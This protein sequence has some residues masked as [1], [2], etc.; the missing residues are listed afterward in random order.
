VD[1]AGRRSFRAGLRL[2]VPFAVASFLLST[3]FGVIARETGFSLVAAVV[4]SL[5]VFAGSAQ[6]AAV[7]VL[8]SGGGPGA[9]VAAGT[10]M[11]ARFLPMGVALAPSLPGRAWWRGLQGQAV[12]DSSWAVASRGD[13]TFDRWLLFGTTAPQLVAWQLGTLVG[14]YGGDLLGDLERFG[15]DAV[16][17]VF[18]LSIL[19]PELRDRSRLGVAVVGGLLALALVPVAP[20]GVPVLAAGLAALWGL[21]RP[22]PTAS[23][24]TQDPS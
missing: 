2:G 10:L 11:N 8:A 22:S 24:P 20:P 6:F 13:G 4:M 23:A 9:A 19:L 18:F 15:L 1:A 5:V 14:A 17:P 21:R 3:S 16:Y 12:V 7:A